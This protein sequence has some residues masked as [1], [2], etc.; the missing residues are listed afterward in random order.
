[1]QRN[2]KSYFRTK[3]GLNTWKIIFLPSALT[4]LFKETSLDPNV[5]V[6]P[7]KHLFST[8]SCKPGN[9]YT[10]LTKLNI[11]R[12]APAFLERKF[13]NKRETNILAVLRFKIPFE[14]DA[15]CFYLF[16]IFRET[17]FKQVRNSSL[18]T[19]CPCRGMTRLLFYGFGEAR[20][21]FLPSS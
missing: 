8:W 17:T 21:I 4:M 10:A 14:R 12:F 15:F 6:S 3:L 9:Y 18:G 1:M 5:A 20:I 11:Q 13:Y 7:E 2:H 16:G 19:L